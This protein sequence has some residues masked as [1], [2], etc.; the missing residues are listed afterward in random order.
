MSSLSAEETLAVSKVIKK[1]AM[2]K[3]RLNVSVGEHEVNCLVRVQGVITVGED[4]EKAQVNTIDWTGLVAV[5]LSKLNGVTVEKLI[6]DYLE[7]DKIDLKDI[8]A[9]AKTHIDTLKGTTMKIDNG[10]VTTKLSF[11]KVEELAEV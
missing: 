5:A 2:D 11:E 3:A 6:S 7:M 1:G 4:Y 10:K 9:S 8:K